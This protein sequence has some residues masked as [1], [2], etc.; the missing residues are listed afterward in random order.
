M[1]QPSVGP[2]LPA[3]LGMVLRATREPDLWQHCPGNP[4]FHSLLEQIHRVRYS[5]CGHQVIWHR[6]T[7]VFLH[8]NYITV[9][10]VYGVNH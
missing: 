9:P 3:G 1:E 2:K 8:Y 5:V 7:Y 6:F 10:Q 4:N